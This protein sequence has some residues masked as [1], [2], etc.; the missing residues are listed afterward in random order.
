MQT[1]IRYGLLMGAALVGMAALISGMATAQAPAP[2]P[3]P[4]LAPALPPSLSVDLMTAQGAGAL[5]AQWR[6]MEA[7]IVEGPAIPNHMPGYEKS[8]D[9]TPH[10]GEAGF[11]DSSW[12]KIEPK[13]LG[14][15]RGGGKVSFLWFRT[16]LT[17]PAKIGDFD[18]TGAKAVLTAYVDDYAEVWVNGQMPRRLGIVSPATIAGFNM[19]NR[20]V[21]ADSVKP[22]DKFEIAVFGINGP[23]S[24]APMNFVFFR[25]ASIEFYK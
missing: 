14:A 10:A 3:P 18:P 11:D 13:D 1:K 4:Q 15:R 25:Q 9:L 21:L 8:Y 17:V 23:I 12:P 16:S 24:V 5:G 20:V 2:A 22:G 6:T 7:K 19:P